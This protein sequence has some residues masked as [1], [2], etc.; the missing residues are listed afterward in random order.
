MTSPRLSASVWLGAG[1][2][3]LTMAGQF[4]TFA[5]LTW[6][7][8]AL[9]V[10][11]AVIEFPATPRI[12]KLITCVLVGAGL[13]L[14]AFGARPLAALQEGMA[15]AEMFFVLFVAV[16][17]LRMPADRSPALRAAQEAAIRQPAGRRDVFLALSA[18][19]IG[20]VLNLAGLT[21]VASIIAGQEDGRVRRRLAQDISQAFTAAACW[22]PFF[23]AMTMVLA[24]VPGVGWA[25]VAPLGLVQSAALMMASLALGRAARRRGGVV[26]VPAVRPAPVSGWRVIGI[27]ASLFA[28][29]ILLS[30]G[31]S[32]S[33]PIALGFAGPACGLVWWLAQRGRT[34][35]ARPAAAEFGRLVL[36]GIPG[37]RGEALL[38]LAASVFGSGLAAAVSPAAA[39]AA[40][41]ALD[42]GPD[43]TI[44]VLLTAMLALGAAGVHGVILVVVVGQMLPPEVLQLPVPAYAVL[45]LAMWG[46][47]TAAS[48]AAPSILYVARPAGVEPWVLAWR[49][50]GPYAVVATA[51]VAAMAVTARHLPG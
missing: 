7:A 26:T 47:A 10:L 12:S 30:E 41:A 48:P 2:F 31:A 6:L 1:V 40:L 25:D 43:A 46:I 32:L 35:K 15:R 4:V 21:L 34:T 3:L 38:F 11:Y 37:L 28:V 36:E 29:V 23:S 5:P 16:M 44:I 45:L 50:N 17:C 49:W 8:S 14:A 20:S 24:T 27:L 9:L 18:H 51:L 19:G 39:K 22:T 33:I 13:I 42:L